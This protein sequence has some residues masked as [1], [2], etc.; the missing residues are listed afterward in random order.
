M[1]SG[2]DGSPIDVVLLGAQDTQSQGPLIITSSSRR[3]IRGNDKNCCDT[4]N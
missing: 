2:E 3:Q 4:K 1:F